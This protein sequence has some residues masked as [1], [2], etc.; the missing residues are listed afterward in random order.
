MPG[1]FYI[2]GK[3]ERVDISGILTGVAALE[4]KL[5]DAGFGLAALRALGDAVEGKLDHSA[6]GLA[7]LK[8][9]IDALEAKE[10]AIKAQTDLLAG[11][12]PAQ[13]STTANWN[14][15]ESEVVSI[16]ADDARYKLHSFV[17]SIHN[18]VGT[19][20]TVRLYMEV[21][22]VERKVYEQNFDA[23]A[24]PPGLWIANG[25]VGIHEVLRVTLQSNNAADDGK[26]VDYDYM[27]E[28]MQ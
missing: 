25:A 24:D 4:N 9:L 5:D 18:L 27:L 20:I 10:D 13:G 23:A 11:E 6:H 17:L 12:A 1:E 7:A 16:G 26:A 28:A 22:G 14:A 21:N 15:A 19:V 2:E 8:V 3:K